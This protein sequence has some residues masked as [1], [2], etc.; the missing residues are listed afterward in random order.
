MHALDGIV[1]LIPLDRGARRPLHLQVCDGFR[2][3][4]ARAEL[5]PGQR[6]PSSRQLAAALG[7]SRMPVLTAYAQLTAEGYFE[8]RAG[9]GT[10][11]SRALG[12]R[13]RP[14]GGESPEPSRRPRPIS[15]R[16]RRLPRFQRPPWF[17]WGAFGVHQPALDQFPYGAW[18]RLLQRHAR[19]PQGVPVERMHPAGAAQLRE[20]ICAYLLTAR[21][22]HCEASQIIITS[23]S[24]Q[25]V[26]L[27]ARVLCDP[28]T[29][30]WFED[31]GYW[32][33]RNAFV[34]Q[35]VRLVPVPVD[36]EGLQVEAGQRF[37]RRARLAYVT[38]SHQYPLGATMSAA[39]RFQLLH[40]AERNGAWIVE[41]DYDGEYR[42]STKPVE[43][44]HGLDRSR[45]VIY[46][47]TFSKVMFP[48]LRLGYLVLP[49]DLVP[50]FIAMRRAA[51]ICPS[52][53]LQAALAD[54]IAEGHFA[55]HIQRTRRVYAERQA[56]LVELLRARLSAEWKLYG[57][58][59]GLHLTMATSR[60]G[61]NDVAIA[62]EA[63]R[64]ELRLWPLSPAYW[65]RP[66]LQ[67]FTLG[68]GSVEPNAMPAAVERLRALLPW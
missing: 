65:R 4:I 40:W 8:A 7:L 24:Q 9:A 67:G 31:P 5:R 25:A 38:P 30:V 13:A 42:F 20:A 18:A 68:F 57:E 54:F 35:G 46:I 47:G 63:A 36:E 22:V 2:A 58:G 26:D 6:I 28:G 49:A 32:L 21:S 59:A 53:W 27:C 51:D 64:Q 14:A 29:P 17:G 23:G 66:R 45:R 3:A 12:G 15:A 52:Y 60:R 44:L 34:A 41:D 16:A 39:R 11:I 50:A 33:A 55:R 48:S 62:T 19:R 56:A 43:S 1:P 37:C 61:C 10:C